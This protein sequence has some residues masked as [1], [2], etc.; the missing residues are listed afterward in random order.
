MGVMFMQ[1]TGDAV[2]LAG[3]QDRVLEVWALPEWGRHLM[4]SG[5]CAGSGAKKLQPCAGRAASCC[6]VLRS[7]RHL[8]PRPRAQAT[9]AAVARLLYVVLLG[10][11]APPSLLARGTESGC[12]R[13]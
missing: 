4:L 11:Q 1:G 2:L 8:A 9:P 10:L 5:Q 7:I 13:I 6:G 12:C 3:E